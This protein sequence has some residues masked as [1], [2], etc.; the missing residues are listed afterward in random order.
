MICR[1]YRSLNSSSVDT[2]VTSLWHPGH[3]AAVVVGSI[4][5]DFPH[6]NPAVDPEIFAGIKASAAVET[7]PETVVQIVPGTEQHPSGETKPRASQKDTAQAQDQSSHWWRW[8]L[9]IIA[10]P[11]LLMT[12]IAGILVWII[13]IPFKFI[14]WPVG[15]L[16]Q[17][18]WN[19]VEYLIKAPLR[20]MLWASGAEW[21]PEQSEKTHSS[22]HTP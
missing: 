4:L 22:Q 9:V 21:R 17:F 15:M 18:L 3:G 16:A 13:L 7:S 5:Y 2:P 8:L 6:P 14:C 19:I 1:N 12:T 20:A 10:A 11:L